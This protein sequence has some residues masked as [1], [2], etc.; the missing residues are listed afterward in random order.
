LPLQVQNLSGWEHRH[1]FRIPAAE[2]VS[3]ENAATKHL[4]R[5]TFAVMLQ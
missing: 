5:T 1:R 2:S 4:D 3:N